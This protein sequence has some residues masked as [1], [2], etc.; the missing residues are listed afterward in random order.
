MSVPSALAQ[1][2]SRAPLLEARNL[3]KAFGGVR[4]VQNI[5]LKI[6]PNTIFSII[7]PNGAGKST[8]LNL[9]S[10]IYHADAGSL[11]FKGVDIGELP[12]HR[13]V[14][15]GIGRTFQKIRLFKNLTTLDNVLAGFHLYHQIPLWQYVFPAGA[16]RKDHDTFLEKAEELLA[17]VGLSARSSTLAGSLSYGE[18]RMLE[19]ARA[20][21]TQ[22]ALL[23]L[24]EPAAGL[25][26]LEVEFLMSQL[27]KLRDHGST[28]LIVEHNMDLVMNI[29]DHVFVMN[30]GDY[31]FEGPPATV[32]RNPDVISA[33]LGSE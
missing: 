25:N 12:L 9:L 2:P 3:R 21:A 4:A 30:H 11:R 28:L 20:L 19:I 8:T 13:R 10:G 33:Y 16:F 18:Q 5:S 15:L 27:K 32:Q 1:T 23:M 7:G 29:A 22:P 31:L 24:D 26:G 17:F 6:Q 14:R